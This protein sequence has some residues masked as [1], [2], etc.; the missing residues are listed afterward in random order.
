MA[1]R[2]PPLKFKKNVKYEQLEFVSDV[3]EKEAT[4]KSDGEKFTSRYAFINYEGED[5]FTPIS[6]ALYWILIDNNIG[7]GSI[8]DSLESE[9]QD[10]GKIKWIIFQDGKQLFSGDQ[11][12]PTPKEERD[13]KVSK[14]RA[15]MPKN[16]RKL[17]PITEGTDSV[18]ALTMYIFT[19]LKQLGY[20]EPPWGMVG[21]IRNT[22]EKI[23]G[24]LILEFDP[25]IW[26][27]YHDELEKKRNN[28]LKETV[29]E[30]SIGKDLQKKQ[31]IESLK[32]L[33]K[34]LG[35]FEGDLNTLAAEAGLPDKKTAYHWNTITLNQLLKIEPIVQKKWREKQK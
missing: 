13:E 15:A 2:S 9:E 19:Q 14:P 7:K 20:P 5:R 24:A 6:Q 23:Y 27:D 29:K 30:E 32:P 10:D 25:R 12:P 8:L 34:D 26:L 21:G 22:L 16:S 3:M 18:C 1:D 31:L 35:N 28:N 4:R 11:K 17:P 33:C